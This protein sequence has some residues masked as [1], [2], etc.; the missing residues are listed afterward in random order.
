MTTR[1]VVMWSGGITSWATA[2][3]VIA[4]HGGES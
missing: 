2:R 3:H 1:H 4:E